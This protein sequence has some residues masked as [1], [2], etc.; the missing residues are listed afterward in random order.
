LGD[1][2][3]TVGK[4]LQA[5]QRILAG[6]FLI[7]SHIERKKT[8]L[9]LFRA[10]AERLKALFVADIANDFEIQLL[11]RDAERRAELLRQVQ[12]YEAEGFH[13]IARHMRQRA[14]E[15]DL[16]KP[17]AGLLPAIAHLQENLP[18]STPLLPRADGTASY[19]TVSAQ[20]ALLPSAKKKGR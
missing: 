12:R 16:Q 8:M 20:Q 4:S 2:A 5:G 7:K 9:W 10:L 19:K 15:I 17:L 14:E 1:G 18:E 3:G 11:T 13:G 6:L